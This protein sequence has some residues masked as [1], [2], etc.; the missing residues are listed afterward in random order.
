MDEKILMELV[1]GILGVI[2]NKVISIILYG[3]AARG[4]NTEESDVDVAIL[5]QGNL[6]EETEDKLSD[7]IVDMN[8]EY[9]KV[10]SVIDIDYDTFCRWQKVTPFYQ[11]VTREGVVLWK[12]A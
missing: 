9:D 4:T 6:D 3:S 7:F 1:K 12:A 10:F 5:M 2:E 11:N 8:L